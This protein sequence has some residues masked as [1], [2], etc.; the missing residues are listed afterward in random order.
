MRP[1]SPTERA[2]RVF[3]ALEAF[4][5][6]FHFQFLRQNKE[7]QSLLEIHFWLEASADKTP[8][9]GWEASRGNKE[10]FMHA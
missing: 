5:I 1:A 2:I 8:E 9:A 6:L 7:F 4:Q 10:N 3:R